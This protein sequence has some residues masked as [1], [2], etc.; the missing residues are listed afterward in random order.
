MSDTHAIS[1]A[2]QHDLAGRVGRTL[3][4]QPAAAMLEFE[5]A[6][7]PRADSARFAAA[8]EA[9]LFGLLPDRDIPI[10]LAIRNRPAHVAALWGLVAARRP[11]A[12]I[13]P[14]QDAVRIADE[15]RAH[16]LAVVIADQQDL[17]NEAVR[18]AARAAATSCIQLSAGLDDPQ[19]ADT[20]GYAGD[21]AYR[22]SLPG[23]AI[24][25]LSSGTSGAPKRIPL[26][27][28]ALG[29]SVYERHAMMA[30]WMGESTDCGS[31]AGALIQY[32]PVVH[33]GGLFI[34]LQAAMEGRKL[35]LLEKFE[36]QRWREAVRR[37]RPSLL[38][39][40][41][42]QMRMVLD[43]DVPAEDLA[44]IK[45]ARSGNALLDDETRT[46]FE[47]RYHVPVLNVYGATEY[48]GPIASWS[49]E[50]H[51]RFAAAKGQSVGRV[52][53]HIAQAR[54]LDANTGNEL[55]VGDTGVLSVRIPS[56]GEEWI[57]TNDLAMLDADG[58]LYLTGRADDAINRGGFKIH[59]KAIE[60]VL[61]RH[62]A[63]A[64]AIVIGI[65]DP[66]LGAVPVAAV[67]QRAGAQAAS[68]EQLRAFLREHLVAYQVPARI[69]VVEALPRTPGLKVSRDGVRALFKG[70]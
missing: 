12:F 47:A 13:N 28:Q 22:D 59:P 7:W 26:G 69:K 31:P 60:D 32:G 55:P 30:R 15:I 19:W 9:R 20:P 38:G 27:R 3:R 21:A 70:T 14:F 50:D 53:P 51:G 25:M 41:P 63:V 68:E 33:L 18:S 56:V 48:C 1:P 45:A 61:R 62:P 46:R 36:V 8:L 65:P 10:G 16:R 6:E 5:G 23:V 66:R 11:V 35:V 17:M 67:Q 44:G 4:D 39:L 57:T 37:H 43:A 2:E 40:P 24:E 34:A 29:F 42:A 64:D 58:F 49:F 54:I 52:W